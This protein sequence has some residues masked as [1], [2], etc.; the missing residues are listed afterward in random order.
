[1]DKFGWIGDGS[2]SLNRSRILT[3]EKVQD[4]DSDP[5]QNILEQDRSRSLKKWLRPP[6][7][8]G[9]GRHQSRRRSARVDS[10]RS[11]QFLPEQ[12]PVSEFWMKNGPRAG[13]KFLLF[14]GAG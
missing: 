6:L 13:V 7:K 2:R 11:L 8:V 1:M 4:P 3:F 5:D 10:G 14:T 9:P 12:D